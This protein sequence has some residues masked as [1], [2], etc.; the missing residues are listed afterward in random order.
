MN[1]DGTG[2]AIIRHFN[3]D[4]EGSTPRTALIQASNGLVYGTTAF[5]SFTAGGTGGTLFQFGLD[6]GGF[7][8]VRTFDTDSSGADSRGILDLQPFIILPVQLTSFTAEQSNGRVE[9]EWSTATEEN[10]S[11]FVVLRSAN[12]TRYDS[13]GMVAA[14]ISNS[15]YQFT[16]HHPLKGM[17]YYRLK[18]VDKDGSFR[19][20][21]IVSIRIGMDGFTFAPNPVKDK[22]KI[23]YPAGIYSLLQVI[24]GSGKTCLQKRILS[25]GIM[26]IDVQGLPAGWY[27]LR[28]SGSSMHQVKFVKE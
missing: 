1:Q 14:G 3:Y 25:T 24:D 6:G 19:H 27:I 8:V 26:E 13:I 10:S 21:R 17:N 15:V 20:S 22:L 16:D 4:I 5:S 12:G 11:H 7:S 23:Y 18:V 28:L 9:L 2:Y